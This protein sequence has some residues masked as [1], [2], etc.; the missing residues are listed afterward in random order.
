MPCTMMARPWAIELLE[1][2]DIIIGLDIDILTDPGARILHHRHWVIAL[3][4]LAT[5]PHSR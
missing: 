1:A 5:S 2:R 3:S 4:A